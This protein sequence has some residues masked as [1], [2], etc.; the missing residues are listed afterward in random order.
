M[1]KAELKR[2]KEE[3]NWE[4]MVKLAGSL[5]DSI[6]KTDAYNEYIAA[7]ER[8]NQDAANLQ[9]LEELREHQYKM[10]AFAP[11]DKTEQKKRILDEIYM[12]I[13]LNPIVS[14]YLNAEY[15]LDLMMEEIRKAFGDLFDF[16]DEASG[17]E[18]FSTEYT[19]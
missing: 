8:L 7:R 2:H 3:K 15:K 10:E 13:S 14:D 1:N 17:L 5:A 6:R 11:D 19:S 9:I 4:S 12:A 18:S 16:E